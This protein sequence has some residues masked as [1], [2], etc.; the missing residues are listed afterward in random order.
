MLLVHDTRGCSDAITKAIVD[1]PDVLK[2]GP[3]A[4]AYLIHEVLLENVSKWESKEYQVQFVLG[5]SYTLPREVCEFMLAQTL[6]KNQLITY[7]KE[8]ERS[9]KAKT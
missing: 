3:V 8:L 7:I 6:Q 4:L 9:V 1:R 2:E 5:K